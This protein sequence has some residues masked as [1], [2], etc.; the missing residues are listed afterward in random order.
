MPGITGLAQVNGRNIWAV[1][2]YPTCH[3]NN[4]ATSNVINVEVVPMLTHSVSITVSG[5]GI[6][7]ATN[8]TTPRV[9]P[10]DGTMTFV[11][12]VVNQGNGYG[13]WTL[14][15][16]SVDPA[17]V[18]GNTLTLHNLNQ[19]DYITY[20]STHI[21]TSALTCVNAAVVSRTVSMQGN[22]YITTAAGTALEDTSICYN[23][24]LTL[25]I[26]DLE[27]VQDWRWRRRAVNSNTWSTVVSYSRQETLDVNLTTS[28]YYVAQVR[29]TSGRN[30]Y[31]NPILVNISTPV[32]YG[33]TLDGTIACIGT[34]IELVAEVGL[35][36][37]FF[38]DNGAANQY[39]TRLINAT[40]TFPIRVVDTL[41][42]TINSSIQI[43]AD[44]KSVV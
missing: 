2:T 40:Q 37:T 31:T 12:N 27:G 29:T 6:A 7:T 24:P 14:N 41:G 21:T 8:P 5:N 17:D 30:Y 13:V 22:A 9:I 32:L 18:V 44:R 38:I 26:N 11:V 1:L 43:V 25:K 42:C 28:Y 4:P 20:T 15:G 36:D 19:G 3:N 10:T 39:V 34:E 23:T 35:T 33:K 16:E